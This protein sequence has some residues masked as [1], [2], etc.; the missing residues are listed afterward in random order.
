MKSKDLSELSVKELMKKKI[1]LK[2]VLVV[3]MGILSLLAVGI[4]A[5]FV[6]KQNTVALPLLVVLFSLSSIL[7]INKKEFS[8]TKDELEKRNNNNDMI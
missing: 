4:I 3:L 5:L 2:T 8:D 6:Q 7:F 1:T